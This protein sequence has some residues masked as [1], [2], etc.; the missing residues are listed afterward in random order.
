MYPLS[1]AVNRT[2][3]KP[4]LGEYNGDPLD[5]SEWSGMFL[6]T[7]DRNTISD[8]NETLLT[9]PAKRARAGMGYSGVMYNTAWKTL[10]RKFGQPP[11][12]MRSQLT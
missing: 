6:L 12:I 4:K 5:W 9:E 3:Q 10:E 7:V 8:E 1:F 11:L 2:L